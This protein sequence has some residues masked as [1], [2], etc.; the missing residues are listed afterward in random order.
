MFQIG[1]GEVVVVGIV[2]LFVLGP[3]RLPTVAR[4]AARWLNRG[5]N[6]LASLKQEFDEEVKNTYRPDGTRKDD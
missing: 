1:F 3:E 6:A 2:A 5:K 4:I